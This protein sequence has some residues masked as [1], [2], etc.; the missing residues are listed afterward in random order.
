MGV[1]VCNANKLEI[2]LGYYTYRGDDVGVFCPLGDLTKVEVFEMCRF[3]NERY[4]NPIP[5]EVLPINNLFDFGDGIAPSAE[6]KEDQLD[7]IKFGYHDRLIEEVMNFKKANMDDFAT[8]YFNGELRTNLGMSEALW[9]KYKLN[10]PKVFIDDLEWF[11]GQIQRNVFKR[12]QA[13]PIVLL[14]KTAYGFD[15][16]ES[17]F[18]FETSFYYDELRKDILEMES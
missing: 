9:N 5:K 16:R 4:D 18:V 3:I 7:P 8:A 12:I 11:F 14:S 1:T 10:E 17:Q 15:Y 2:A 13:P 6:L